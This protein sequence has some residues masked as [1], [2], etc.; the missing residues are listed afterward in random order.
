MYSIIGQVVKSANI[1]L[2][3][4]EGSI[5]AHN[6]VKGI[7]IVEIETAEGKASFKMIKD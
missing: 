6:L 5:D 4:N 1:P 7:Y 2:N 3:N